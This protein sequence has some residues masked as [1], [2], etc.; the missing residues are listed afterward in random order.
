LVLLTACNGNVIVGSGGSAATTTSTTAPHT[1]TGV[2]ST[3]TA[4]S[5]GTTSTT[6]CGLE[7]CDSTQACIDNSGACGKGPASALHCVT[8]GNLCSDGQAVC[9]CDGNVYMSQG[10]ALLAGIGVDASNK[11]AAP[12]SGFFCGGVACLSSSFYCLETAHPDQ[13]GVATTYECMQL[14]AACNG[15]ASCGCLPNCGSGPQPQ[16]CTI[17]ASGDATQH[18]FTG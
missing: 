7:M 14:P 17:D 16:T 18:C 12:P 11:C 8:K 6:V 2:T 15:A 4:T 13:P 9:G 10:C 5:T 3:T 1:T